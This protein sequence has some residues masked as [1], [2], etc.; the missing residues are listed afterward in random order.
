M[1]SRWVFEGVC[2]RAEPPAPRVFLS[3]TPATQ[4]PDGGPKGETFLPSFV[5]MSRGAPVTRLAH[6]VSA[7]RV[8]FVLHTS[9]PGY[10]TRL[11]TCMPITLAVS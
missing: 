8:S 5:G 9:V 10:L 6:G 4:R 2:A 7:P 3:N 1:G 11:P